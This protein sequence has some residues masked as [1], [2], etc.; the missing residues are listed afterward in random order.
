MRTLVT[1]SLGS[2]ALVAGSATAQTVEFVET[3]E[4][5]S[6]VGGWSW[7]TGNQGFSPLNGNPG[8]FL[9]DLSL[10]SCCPLLSTAPGGSSSFTGNWILR[11]VRHVGIDLVTLD[12]DFGIGDRPL[13]VEL[14]NDAGTPGNFNDDWG[15]WLVGEVQVP[16]PGVPIDGPA[17]WTPFSFEVDARAPSLPLG[18]T[19]FGGLGSDPAKTWTALMSDVDR[20]GYFYGDPT[21]IFLVLSWDVGADNA[22]IAVG[23]CDQNGIADFQELGPTTDLDS[24]GVLDA[25][26]MLSATTTS[27]SLATGGS[28]SFSLDAGADGAGLLYL[29]LGS[30]T[31]TAPAIAVDGLLVPLAFDGYTQFTLANPNQTPWSGSLGFLDPTGAATASLALPA[32]SPPALAGAMLHHA[33]VTVDLAAS[34]QLDSASNAWSIALTP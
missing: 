13:T 21:S 2:F 23:D 17:G 32:G 30:L 12:T 11:D 10:V 24:N 20:L 16:G 34:G 9:E 29:I 8:A 27:L 26:E 6:N 7:G 31:G 25:C 1:V 19:P 18:W 28:A 4:G 5:S 14:I 15:A 22:R 3:F 33:F